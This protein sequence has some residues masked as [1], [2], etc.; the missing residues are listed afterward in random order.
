MRVIR[1]KG[2]SWTS[3]YGTEIRENNEGEDGKRAYRFRR[4]PSQSS[5]VRSTENANDLV[6]LI[7]VVATAEKRNTRDHPV[8]E[9]QVS[10]VKGKKTGEEGRR[11]R[12]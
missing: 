7:V 3:G 9:E 11:T 8:R 5:L 10:L 4:N 12:P 1:G 2:R 6:E